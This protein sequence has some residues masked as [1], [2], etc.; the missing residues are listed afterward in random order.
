MKKL[1][2][3]FGLVIMT[4]FQVGCDS[5]QS[6]EE[7]VIKKNDNVALFREAQLNGCIECHRVKATVVGPSWFEIAERYKDIPKKKARSLLIY[8][9]KKGSRGK[10]ATWKGGNGM[11]ALENRVKDETIEKMVDYILQL[12]D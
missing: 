8:S 1:S 10:F 6:S 4:A 3:L 9:V 2:L 7:S 5:Q 12:N 11:P